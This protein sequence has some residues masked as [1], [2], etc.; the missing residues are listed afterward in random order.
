M[1]IEKSKL[2]DS[3]SYSVVASNEISQISEFFNV[4]VNSKPK[5]LEKLGKDVD[6]DQGDSITLKVDN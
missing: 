6:C 4:K 3:G 5:F 2:S 1:V